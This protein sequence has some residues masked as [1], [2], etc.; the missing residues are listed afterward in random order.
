MISHPDL[1]LNIHAEYPMTGLPPRTPITLPTIRAPLWTDAR[2][3][4]IARG[5]EIPPGSQEVPPL[6]RAEVA[7]YDDWGQLAMRWVP[8]F[9]ATEFA[10]IEREYLPAIAARREQLFLAEGAMPPAD[11]P[12]AIV[13][14]GWKSSCEFQLT[15]P[16]P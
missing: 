5:E 12:A 16:H 8:I 1:A 10:R 9:C 6:R 15:N 3:R 13:L 2:Y 14:A 4:R 7:V 11:D